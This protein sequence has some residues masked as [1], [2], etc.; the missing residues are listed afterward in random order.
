V[1]AGGNLLRR[2]LGHDT[3]PG[4][5]FLQ[6]V[7]EG[8]GRFQRLVF[9]RNRRVMIS[10]GDGGETLRVHEVFRAAPE[11][12]QRAI[13]GL[14]ARGAPHR[15]EAARA[16]I[17]DFL[18]ANAPSPAA[19]PPRTRR[20]QPADGATLALLQEEFDRVNREHFDS[21]LPR[22][23]IHLSGRM[24]RR[25]GHFSTAP[26]E[27]VISRRLCTEA[28]AGEAER[29]LRHEMIHL[30]QHARGGRPDHGAEFRRWAVRLEVHPRATRQ[31]E[32]L[33]GC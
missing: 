6:R 31:V 32:W 23:P 3:V 20:Q 28:A 29:T 12:V 25:N 1:S 17:R 2:L 15:R 7:Q 5:P 8:G 9:T 16:V 14:Y 13:G 27:I 22:V 33:E 21:T 26:L 10:V 4:E 30:W 24:R 11:E 19:A 18:V